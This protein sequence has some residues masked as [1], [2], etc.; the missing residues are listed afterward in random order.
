MRPV[1]SRVKLAARAI[2][3]VVTL[4]MLEIV[5]CAGG[6]LLRARGNFYDPGS[7][8]GFAEYLEKRDPELNG[9][10][11]DLPDPDRDASG[12]RISPAFPDPAVAPCASLYGDSF[13]FSDEVDHEHAWGNVLAQRAGCRV[14]NHGV[15]GYGTDQAYLRFRRQKDDRPKVALLGFATVDVLRNVNQFR[16]LIGG[17]MPFSFKPRFIERDDGE[18]E[19]VPMLLPSTEEE[20]RQIA[21]QPA[22]YLKHEYFLPGGPSGVSVL[23]FPYLVS[24]VRLS[25]D[26]RIRAALA[27]EPSHAPFLSPDHPSRGLQV[28]AGI[29]R[30][31]AKE[32]A[33]RGAWGA[34][35]IIPIHT[36]LEHLQKKG[37]TTTRPLVDELTRAG[38]PVVDATEPLFAALGGRAPCALYTKCPAGHFTEEGY[39]LLAEIVHG[40]LKEQGRL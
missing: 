19:L 39:R 20:Y 36:D 18:L 23:S 29:G 24:L 30:L 27:G 13:T 25:G 34:V 5:S 33:G 8:E 15:P 38:V 40:W 21:L 31:F 4:L 12:A 2:V 16:A 9:R 32:A 10:R 7:T 17:P 37:A 3:V 22:R 1:S 11:A 6:R 14:A 26:F 28:T 35:V